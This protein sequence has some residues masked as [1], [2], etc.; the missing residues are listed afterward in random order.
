M[1]LDVSLQDEVT[2]FLLVAYL[3]ECKTIIGAD[4]EK[5]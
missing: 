2:L 4:L 3:T 1:C 5:Y